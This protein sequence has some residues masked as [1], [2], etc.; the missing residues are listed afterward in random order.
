[1]VVKLGTTKWGVP[2]H[3]GWSLG[4]CHFPKFIYLSLENQHFCQ[5][6]LAWC[7]DAAITFTR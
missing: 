3:M 2:L 7:Y 5:D 4:Q 1:M 6:M